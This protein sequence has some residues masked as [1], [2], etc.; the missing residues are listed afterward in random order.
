MNDTSINRGNRILVGAFTGNCV[1]RHRMYGTV[2]CVTQGGTIWFQA[3]EGGSEQCVRPHLGEPVE[4]VH[5][6]KGVS[7]SA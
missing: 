6:N 3:D 5:G 4:R 1:K 7:Q 2:T